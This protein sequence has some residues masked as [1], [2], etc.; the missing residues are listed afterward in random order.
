MMTLRQ[1]L[2]C[3]L[4]VLLVSSTVAAQSPSRSSQNH[5]PPGIQRGTPVRLITIAGTFQGRYIGVFEDSLKLARNDTT[6]SFAR[7]RIAEILVRRR[8]TRRGAV[9][10]VIVGAALGAALGLATKRVICAEP[11]NACTDEGPVAASVGLS[12]G[13][14]TGGALGA[15]V[16]VPITRW[17][18]IDR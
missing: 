10:G 13:G 9:T 11:S 14:L 5:W 4:H 3:I 8:M 15:M 18:R 6:H 2:M 1:Q 17:K 7:A 16:G 12:V